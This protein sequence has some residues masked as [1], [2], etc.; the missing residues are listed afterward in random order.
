MSMMTIGWAEEFK[1]YN[2]AANSLMAKNNDCYCGS[3]KYIGWGAMLKMSRTPEILADAAYYILQQ[4][5]AECTGN[6]F[7]DEQ[8]LAKEGI[9]DLE[10]YAVYPG[11]KLYNDLICINR[12]ILIFRTL[13]ISPVFSGRIC[14]K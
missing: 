11:A 2:I 9:T 7:I 1:K 10:K 4:P 8:V 14:G 6:L 13:Y 12:K 5:S 3:K